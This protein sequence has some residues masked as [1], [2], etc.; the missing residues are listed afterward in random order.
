MSIPIPTNIQNG[1][2]IDAS[3]VMANFNALGAAAQTSAEVNEAV[4]LA[5]GRLFATTVFD[6]NGTWTP[7]AATKYWEYELV[8]GGGAGGGASATSSTQWSMADAGSPGT[9]TKGFSTTVPGPTAVTVGAGGAP[10][11]GGAGGAGGTSSV[12]AIATAPGGGGGPVN[13]YTSTTQL[14]AGGALPGA[15]GTG[16]N[17]FSIPGQYSSGMFV[18]AGL[19]PWGKAGL[20]GPWGGGASLVGTASAG[21]AAQANTG[22]SGGGSANTASASALTGGT[23]GSGKVIIREY[24]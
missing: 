11:S 14:Y 5:S 10:V 12:G 15:A 18:A 23:G 3:P 9:Y 8:G 22:A 21:I 19:T 13:T 17:I 6:S 16:G 1:Q 2:A 20:P 7:N 24:T 4:A